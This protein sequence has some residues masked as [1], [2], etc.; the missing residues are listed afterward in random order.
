MF[1]C[2]GMYSRLHTYIFFGC[3]G[4]SV[5]KTSC[6]FR[7]TGHKNM[8]KYRF[9]NCYVSCQLENKKGWFFNLDAHMKNGITFVMLFFTLETA[10]L[11]ESHLLTVAWCD[12]RVNWMAW[13]RVLRINTTL[14]HFVLQVET[15]ST[16]LHLILR[17]TCPKTKIPING[18]LPHMNWCPQNT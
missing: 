8:W 14:Y 17:Q 10:P 1:K 2:P 13:F 18:S 15:A 11:R 6:K 7:C 3:I 12:L 16:E 9:W 5:I 4:T